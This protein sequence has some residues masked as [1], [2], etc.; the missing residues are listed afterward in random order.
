MREN[1]EPD[2]RSAKVER[3]WMSNHW[4]LKDPKAFRDIPLAHNAQFNAVCSLGRQKNKRLKCFEQLMSVLPEIC[5]THFFTPLMSKTRRIQQNPWG[6]YQTEMS[7][8]LGFKQVPRPKDRAWSL[9]LLKCQ[10]WYP[11][12]FLSI[13]INGFPLSDLGKGGWPQHKPFLAIGSQVVH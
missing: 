10:K 7:Q 1:N 2:C 5:F 13:F 4:A 3:N 8:G 6:S 12:V 11:S 9:C